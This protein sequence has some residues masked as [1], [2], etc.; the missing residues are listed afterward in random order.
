MPTSK[1][2]KAAKGQPCQVRLPGICSFDPAKTILAHQNGGG[3]ARKTPDFM[4]AFCCTD[5]HSIVDGG[6][7]CLTR[8]AVMLYFYQGVFRTQELLWHDKLIITPGSKQ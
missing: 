3:M 5:C 8:E 6:K 7:H 4:G 2:R 1:I